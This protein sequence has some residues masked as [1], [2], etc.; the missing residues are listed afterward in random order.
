MHSCIYEGRVVHRRRAPVTHR[1]RY[2]LYMVYLD[3]AE[4]LATPDLRALVPDRRFAWGAFLPQDHLAGWPGALGDGVR[5]L[6]QA[7]TGH[8]PAGP[9][10]LLTQLRSL[11]YYFSPLNLYYCFD[12]QD[13]H[14]DVV[15]AE[16]NNTP[17]REQH[18]YVLW[19]GNRTGRVAAL[20]FAHP[21][22]FHVSPFM[23]MQA[24]YRWT[25]SP[26]GQR[27]H[28]RLENHSPAGKFFDATLSLSQLPITRGNLRRM[29]RRHPWMTGQIVGGIHWQ[30]FRLWWK[31]CPFYTHPRTRS[32]ASPTAWPPGST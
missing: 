28:V 32:A 4:W 29:V 15:V 5:E 6:V 20:Q 30:A 2:R 18:H 8:R 31:K 23:D 22:E 9:V 24:E 7:R 14:V 19:D 11:G 27:L 17:W 16:V 1:F 26:P 13:R 3:L 10:R 12:E 25:L 21:K